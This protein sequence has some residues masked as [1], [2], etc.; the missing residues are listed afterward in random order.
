MK[1]LG[2]HYQAIAWFIRRR[3]RGLVAA[4]IQ[5]GHAHTRMLQGYAGSYDSGFPDE[6]AFEDWLYR[7]E[8]LSEDAEVFDEGEHVSGAAADACPTA[9]PAP[10]ASL[11]DTSSPATSRPATCRETHSSR[12]T[13]A[14]A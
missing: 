1:Q 5:Y 3:P 8:I 14:T 4:A 11:P 6:Y 7:L 10:T 12:S 13:M 9:S 2:G